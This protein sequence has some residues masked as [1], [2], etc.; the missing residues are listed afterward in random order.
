[1]EAFEGHVE[2]RGAP[3]VPELVT[4]EV[5]V[6]GVVQGVGFRPFV[7]RIALR[8]GLDGW[9][10]NETGTVRIM[11]RG[12]L[13]AIAGFVQA[14][15]DE[16][17]PLARLDSLRTGV[18]DEAVR[19]GFRIQGSDLQGTGRLPVSPDVAICDACAEEMRDP[20]NRRYRYP[21]IT[22]TDCGPRFTV[23]ETMPYDRVRTSMRAFPQCPSC[24]EEYEEPLNR[25]YHS[26]TNS[27]PDCGP[28]LWSEPPGGLASDTP[29]ILDAPEVALASAVECLKAG[30]IVAVRGL[31]GFHLAADAT[32][33][34]A[35]TRLRTRKNRWAKPL[36]VMVDSVEEAERLGE[37]GPI[38]RDLLCRPERPIVLLP[39]RPES[40]LA[41][42]VAPGLGMVGVMTPYTPLHHLLLEGVGRPLVMTSGN[43]SEEPIATSNDEARVRLAELA[44]LLLLH[45]REIVARYDDSVVR[46]VDGTPMFVRRARGFAPLPLNLPRGLAVPTLAVGP[47]LKNTFALAEGSSAFVSQHVGDLENL[48]T[49]RHFRESLERFMTLFRVEPRWIV[50]DLHPGYLSS[51]VAGELAQEWGLPEPMTVQHHHAHIAAVA[52]ERGVQR[53]VLG[54]AFDGTGYGD[55]GAVWGCEFLVAD[56]SEYRRVAHLRYAPLP[57]GDLAARR[58]W[59]SALGYLEGMQESETVISSIRRGVPKKEWEVARLQVQKGLNAPPASSLGRLFDAAASVL[60]TRQEASFEGQAPMELEALAGAT[61]GHPLPAWASAVEEG[62]RVLDPRPLLLALGDGR[63]RGVS[64]QALAA[65]FHDAVAESAVGTAVELAR[66]NRLR[67][68]ALGGGVFQNARMLTSVRQGLERAGLEVLVPRALSPNDGSVSFG[69]IA[70]A[71]ARQANASVQLSRSSPALVGPKMQ[72]S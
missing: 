69:Q 61:Q 9:V 44:D 30:G 57:G 35:V 6:Q 15:Q 48:E 22:C 27:C 60:G 7:H 43:V 33:P 72:R 58:P 70:V 38:H 65:G 64:I 5:T 59:R 28:R 47:H 29:G 71:A 8:H 45:D 23:I 1:L 67:H 50:R 55:D 12:P 66:E 36:A 42:Q 18:S 26:E 53:P 32:N 46:V 52:A 37:L 10:R 31:G 51:R 41:P 49:L 16:A 62:V 24:R 40:G 21:F 19:P 56:L 34:E 13:D 39:E 17:P 20:S 68:V 25:R 4:R 63:A 14:L 3:H 11:L 54:L 2:D